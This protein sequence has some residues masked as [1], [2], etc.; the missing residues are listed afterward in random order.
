MLSNLHSKRLDYLGSTYV[1]EQA[2]STMNV[3]KNK[4]PSVTNGHLENIL[5]I[6]AFYIPR[7]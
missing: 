5:R 4:L 1:C 6:S 3:N 2:L 7:I